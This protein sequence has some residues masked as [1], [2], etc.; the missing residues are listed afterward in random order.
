MSNKRLQ[1]EINKRKEISKK[2]KQAESIYFPDEIKNEIAALE[3]ELQSLSFPTDTQ[4]DLEDRIE[5]IPKKQKIPRRNK[6]SERR[7]KEIRDRIARLRNIRFP[8]Q[9][10]QDKLVK[11]AE[12]SV[13]KK[14]GVK[15]QSKQETTEQQKRREENRERRQAKKD[16]DNEFERVPA[17]RVDS[18]TIQVGVGD[19]K[20]IYRLSDTDNQETDAEGNNDEDATPL[21][22][23]IDRLSFNI[24]NEIE[25]KF[26]EEGISTPPYRGQIV[27]LLSETE[28]IVDNEF[29]QNDVTPSI[30]K[31]FDIS[32]EVNKEL[33]VEGVEFAEKDLTIGELEF[34][35]SSLE[36]RLENLRGLSV[37]LAEK[38]SG[39]IGVN[40]LNEATVD[41]LILESDKA[42]D[43]LGSVTQDLTTVQEEIND[44]RTQLQI[45]QSIHKNPG[46]CAPADVPTFPSLVPVYEFYSPSTED[47]IYTTDINFDVTAEATDDSLGRGKMFCTVVDAAPGS[48]LQMDYD[49]LKRNNTIL[50]Q[51][52]VTPD[53]EF[54]FR[55]GNVFLNGE[56]PF[57]QD[58]KKTYLFEGYFRFPFASP[59]WRVRWFNDDDGFMEFKDFDN[60]YIRVLST[61][62]VTQW[63]TNVKY[64]PNGF[65]EVN[66]PGS[67]QPMFKKYS[68][69]TIGE[70]NAMN[71]DIH[72]INGSGENKI[73]PINLGPYTG[74]DSGEVIIPFRCAVSNNG[75]GPVKCGFQWGINSGEDGSPI[76]FRY[77]QSDEF[78]AYAE[79]SSYQFNGVAF[80]AHDP[81]EAKNKETPDIVEV[82]VFQDIPPSGDSDFQLASG[83]HFYGEEAPANN[84]EVLQDNW[85]DL[86]IQFTALKKKITLPHPEALVTYDINIGDDEEGNPII[87]RKVIEDGTPRQVHRFRNKSTGTYRYKILNDGRTRRA[88][89]NNGVTLGNDSD[90]NPLVE[91]L[92]IAE[93]TATATEDGY[94]WEGTDFYAY[95]PVLIPAN[96]PPIIE[97]VKIEYNYTNDG[98]KLTSQTSMLQ[99]NGRFQYP[100]TDSVN[101]M[102]TDGE[103]VIKTVKVSIQANDPD[104]GIIEKYRLKVIDSDSMV[105]GVKAYRSGQ[106]LYEGPDNSTELKLMVGR[107]RIKIE[108][109]DNRDGVTTDEMFLFVRFAR[110]QDAE[111]LPPTSFI[112][113]EYI[114]N[115]LDYTY[116]QKVFRGFRGWKTRTYNGNRRDPA[117]DAFRLGALHYREGLAQPKSF[118]E[119]KNEV[120]SIKVRRKGG[121][122][123]I[124]F[125]DRS[126]DL[127]L[128]LYESFNP[129]YGFRPKKAGRRSGHSPSQTKD[130]LFNKGY[131]IYKQGFESAK[132]PYL[133]SNKEASQDSFENFKIM[134]KEISLEGNNM[135]RATYNNVFE[136]IKKY[137]DDSSFDPTDEFGKLEPPKKRNWLNRFFN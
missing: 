119:V 104:G 87:Q 10:K 135:S 77:V 106:I 12:E 51:G 11:E 52:L 118:N 130:Q 90:G 41:D 123:G 30:F 40:F 17:Y 110:A 48:D 98:D 39:L 21:D 132:I 44:L 65:S 56:G 6:Q 72:C 55:H 47:Y 19:E 57:G 1:K 35:K 58:G 129:R 23:L 136:S 31:P 69:T 42:K 95:E 18:D 99:P 111:I 75:G 63:K 20:L 121:L 45:T 76:S 113:P 83:R 24:E 109:V 116:R 36:E 46:G 49:D 80:S 4:E 27:E 32:Y 59:N 107:H 2:A 84:P 25:E 128:P 54:N 13:K 33:E 26:E 125:G 127:N 50:G 89:D 134:N 14:A 62:A 96:V 124:F 78:S 85:N 38:L 73:G 120:V 29:T 16:L 103:S 108:C 64:N 43:I 97:D 28:A 71:I 133:L 74:T 88:R 92:G 66:A 94:T 9:S 100:P 122:F 22:Q 91:T 5:S 34:A 126:G 79:P 131:D 3:A 67:N 102:R 137:W 81:V 117:L 93:T 37:I 68:S 70:G 115:N 15:N 8:I 7:A 60:K 114:K 105:S 101:E 112:G 53:K 82:K 61:G 86:D